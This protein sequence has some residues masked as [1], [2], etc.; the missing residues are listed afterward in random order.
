MI[1]GCP[2]VV[3]RYDDYNLTGSPKSMAIDTDGNL[4]IG[5]YNGGMVRFFHNKILFNQTD[6]S[7]ILNSFN[8]LIYFIHELIII[9]YKRF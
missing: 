4:W 3:F 6:L 7:N 9:L 1:A 2:T 5:S 8:S